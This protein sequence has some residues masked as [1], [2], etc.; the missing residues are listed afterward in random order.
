MGKIIKNENPALA[1]AKLLVRNHSDEHQLYA[2]VFDD[3][4][5]CL[6][7]AKNPLAVALGQR[8]VQLSRL[9]AWHYGCVFFWNY[10]GLFLY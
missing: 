9:A 2:A 3:S 8:L 5:F 6:V 7:E 10:D 4:P 1:T